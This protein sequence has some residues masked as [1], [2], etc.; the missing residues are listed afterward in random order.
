MQGTKLTFVNAS[1][2][3]ELEA[4]NMALYNILFNG[5][6]KVPKTLAEIEVLLAAEQSG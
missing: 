2:A 6:E 4:K 5:Q 3:K 1:E